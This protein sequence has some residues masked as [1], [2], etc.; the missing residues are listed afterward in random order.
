MLVLV[1]LAV[2]LLAAFWFNR[3]L[4]QRRRAARHPLAKAFPRRELRKLDA[5]LDEVARRERSLLEREFERYL[6]GAVGYVITIYRSPSGIALELSDGRHLA[7][8]G[9]SRRALQ[10]LAPLTAKDLLKPTH[11]HRDALSF[12]IRLRG[13]AGT[14][15]DIY[16]RNIALAC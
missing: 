8:T 10:I 2:T 6:T 1:S 7:L 14:D 4:R 16:A 3:R 12:R 9:V 5:H 11:V 15:I 13:H